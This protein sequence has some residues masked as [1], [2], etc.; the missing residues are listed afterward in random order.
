MNSNN[1]DFNSDYA[2]RPPHTMCNVLESRWIEVTCSIIDQKELK[3]LGYK[4]LELFP[5]S[6]LHSLFKELS[7]VTVTHQLLSSKV[8]RGYQE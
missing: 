8:S 6:L 5:N 7:Q 4:V 3:M 1:L 2:R